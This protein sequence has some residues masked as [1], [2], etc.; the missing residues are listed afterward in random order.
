MPN[1]SELQRGESE[2]GGRAIVERY[3]GTPAI[4]WVPIAH[5]CP[6]MPE[7]F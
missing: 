5:R 7:K 1:P 2:A 4:K 3:I 6:Y